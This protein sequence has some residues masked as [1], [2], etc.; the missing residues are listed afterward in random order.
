MAKVIV[1]FLLIY[2]IKIKIK[3][4]EKIRKLAFTVEIKNEREVFLGEFI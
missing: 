2:H 1:S 3:Y 4:L